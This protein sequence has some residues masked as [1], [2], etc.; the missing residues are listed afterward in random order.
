MQQSRLQGTWI[1]EDQLYSI[2]GSTP[3]DAFVQKGTGLIID[4]GKGVRLRDINGREYI[5]GCSG[6]LSAN[7]GYS[8]PELA[9]AAYDQLL[10]LSWFPS[11]SGVTTTAAIDY[12]SKLAEFLP[13]GMSRTFLVNSGSEATETSYK[14]ARY[15]WANQGQDGKYKIISRQLA[16]HGLNLVSTW[17]TGLDRF[18]KNI[19]PP[20]PGVE[21]IP[22]C[23]C[24]RCPMDQEYPGC[25]L[26]CA[27]SLAETIES[28]G[29]KTVAA[30]IAEPIYG[31]AG[32]IFPPPEYIPKVR[33]ICDRYN[34]LLILD[35]VITGFGRT[36]KNFACQHWGV[37]PDLM[38]M[39]KG[40]ISSHLP[41]GGVALTER[42]FSGFAG[43]DAFQ[44]LYTTGGHSSACAVAQ[45]N[46]EVIVRD[47][48]VDRSAKLGAYMLDR[49]RKLEEYPHVALAQ[50]MG[51]LFGIEL[52]KD[53]KTKEPYSKKEVEGLGKTILDKGIIVRCAD[54][55]ISLGPS[56]NIDDHALDLIF[57]AIETS[58]AEL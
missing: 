50:G 51:L 27:Q 52:V 49:F 2:H 42:I 57:N 43:S 29:P 56:L 18:H 34:V 48:L 37:V 8:H 33:E 58:I 35:E 15:F 20:I 11:H 3:M 16:Y 17:T 1:E 6:A 24:Y 7:V 36:G 53:K 10:K 54:S 19:G 5:D 13:E 31:T 25:D 30:F 38:C 9:R 41:M 28:E 21:K 40:M 32:D 4:Q 26:E 22:A 44:H 45:K 23:Y 47:N 55:R 12:C 39:S 46:L 14:M